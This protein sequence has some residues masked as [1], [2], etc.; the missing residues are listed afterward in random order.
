MTNKHNKNIIRHNQVKVVRA[1]LKIF[2][3]SN[4]KQVI[5]IMRTSEDEYPKNKYPNWIDYVKVMKDCKPNQFPLGYDRYFY[6][7]SN[8]IEELEYQIKEVN[9]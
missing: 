4:L 1:Y 9:N 3:L 6:I 7:C 2:G 5:Y 8:T